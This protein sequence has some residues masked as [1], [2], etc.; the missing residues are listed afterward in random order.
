MKK[1]LLLL[2]TLVC[3]SVWGQ[4]HEFI[5]RLLSQMTIE[6]KV[7]LLHATSPGVPR[8]G[9]SKYYMGNE[10]LHGVVRP[11]RFTVFPQSIGLASMWNPQLQQRIG[12]AVS[13]EAR[14]RWNE[15]EQG[16]KQT[17]QFSDLLVF[18]SPTVN[19]ARDPRWGRTPETYGE[20]PYLSG[21]LGTAYVRGL[22]GDNPQYL[23]VVATPKHFVANNE[24]HNRF[25]CNAAISERIL[26]EYYLPAFERC[27]R[28]GHA[29]SIMSAYNSINEVPCTANPWLLT[30]VLRNEWGFDGFVV[31]DCGAPSLLLTDHHFVKIPETAA[32]LAIKA[33]LDLECG[34]NIF[35]QP[36]LS[37]YKQ[38]MVSEAEIDSAAY[39]VLRFRYRLGMFDD[40]DKNPYNHIPASIVGCQEHQDLALESARQ[41]LVLLKNDHSAL[42]LNAKKLKK[43]AVVGINADKH[44]FGDYSGRPINAPVSVLQGI[45]NRLPQGVEVTHV[46]WV[47][48]NA[49]TS[50]IPA[51][52]FP[53][54][55]HAEYYVGSKLEGTPKERTDKQINLEPKNQA[56]DP[57]LPTS[58]FSVRWTGRLVAPATGDYLFNF[59]TD[60]GGRLY[61]DDKL[62]ADD[63]DIHP[64]RDAQGMVH[65][66]KG[67]SYQVRAE[68]FDDGGECESKLCWRVPQTADDNLLE[69][70]GPGTTQTLQQSDVVIAVMGINQD[71]EREG[72]DRT[73]LTL[74]G[75]QQAFLQ[76]VYEANP[77]TILVLVAGSSLA[78]G[79]EHQHL[80]AI[81]D[82][83][84]PGEAGGTA[85][86]E[87][88]FGD[89]SPAGRLPLTFYNSMDE[90][91]DFNDYDVT[92]GRTYQYF[93]GT[94]LYSFGHGLS[95]TRFQYRNLRL[96]HSAD[97]VT[98]QFDVK[99]VGK[100]DAD[101]V[102]QVYVRYPDQDFVTPI[103]QLRGFQRVSIRKGA[104][105]QVTI[106]I[107]REE[108][109]LWDEARSAF[110]TPTGTYE[111]LVG[112]SSSDIRLRGQVTL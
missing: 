25:E 80:P 34:D 26:R 75:D 62:V 46:P 33:G 112:A 52:C 91:P 102:C 12:T 23:K 55:L 16:K 21:V 79:W 92:K 60:D 95:Y 31:S 15:L 36:L 7:D 99:N 81:L 67:K 61:I 42:P 45:Q 70:F 47:S 32:T 87:A 59:R 6:E 3:T 88:L 68:Y 39:R 22:Q 110:F 103:K 8:L 105:Q 86:A 111:I 108:L 100:M 69:L 72:Q 78:L 71:I 85:V 44:E 109:R 27:V 20:D 19:M 30:Q 82:A 35:I 51:A 98:V 63:W 54:G 83:W 17:E 66:E 49:E 94:P 84:Y 48:L 73:S 57:F 101:E 4:Q 14:G 53:E 64:A 2:L 107:P 28:Q 1:A 9:V 89:F 37:A 38:K 24:E 74:P 65:L 106:S 50:L 58:P 96:Q 97:E 93:Q 76:K 77:N 56:P 11:G 10:A 90:L 29:Q 104:S 43:V 40:P 41:C 18:W 5:L 13:D